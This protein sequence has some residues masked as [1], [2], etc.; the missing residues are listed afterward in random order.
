MKVE[1][2]EGAVVFDEGFLKK[3]EYLYIV[4][5]KL[6]SGQSRAERRTH[7][8]G[9][10]IEF[11]DHRDYTA[12]DDLR[13]IDW[14]VYGRTDRLLL[15]LFEE[16]EDLHIYLL[17]DASRSM[18]LGA[19]P[20][21]ASKLHYASQ[22]AA[23]LCYVGLANLDRVGLAGFSG[24]LGARMSPARGKGR[25]FKVLE[26][27]GGLRAQGATDLAA[28]LRAF[29]HQTKRRGLVVLLSDLYDPAGYQEGLNLL[30]YHRFEPFVVHVYDQQE[31][32]PALRGDL[33]LCD[34]ETGEE[35]ELTVSSKVLE[36]YAAEHARY[37]AEAEEFCSARHVPYFRTHTGV[38][39][40]Q[41][42]LRVFRK[43]GFLG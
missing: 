26:F 24:N 1:E 9:S 41:L 17:I 3:L 28:S 29:V 25:I 20:G 34:C 36:R 4:S 11:A 37:L 16:E 32:R 23:A 10:G 38:P 40:D 31:A 7:K 13:Y 2:G 39:F 30:R 14:N 33:A 18:G 12:G 27:L 21:V 43:G 35:R 42:V 8:V 22:V 5:R 6:L 15:R 19:R